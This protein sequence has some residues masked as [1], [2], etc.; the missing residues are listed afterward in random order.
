[1]STEIL[2]SASKCTMIRYSVIIIDNFYVIPYDFT[3]YY[4]YS[5][6][7]ISHIGIEALRS[8][9]SLPDSWVWEKQVSE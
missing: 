3:D 4:F 1:M 2:N 6:H 9:A 7:C 5:Q 8:K